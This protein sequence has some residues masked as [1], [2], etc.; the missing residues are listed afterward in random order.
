MSGIGRS[1]LVVG[2][3]LM[4]TACGRKGALIYPD[5]L[6]P[7]APSAVTVLQSGAV[8]KMSF[9]IPDKD[10]AGKPVRDVAGIKISR[11]AAD[12]EQKD[13]CRSCM[14]DYT[15]FST[16]YLEHLPTNTQRAG[17]ILF[18]LDGDVS[19]G[20]SYSY[21]IVPFTAGGIQGASATTASVRV[22]HALPAPQLRVES[23]PT[24]LRL[25]ATSQSIPEGTTLLG[26]NLYRWT[27]VKKRSYQPLNREPISSTADYVDSGLER[28][29]LYS[30][31]ARALFKMPSGNVVESAESDVV[32]G[33]LAD[34]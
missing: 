32:A 33:M 2:V 28:R 4:A 10:R 18:I 23:L 16:L 5:M 6:M 26:Y 31:S 27:A 25:H 30:Y 8:V 9:A 7:A 17:S 13:Q 14:A 19:E 24:E 22:V 34:D 15:L 20:Y 21:T 1:A 29:V 3:S 11:K 12:A